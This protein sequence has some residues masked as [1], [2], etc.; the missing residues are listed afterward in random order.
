MIY[1]KVSILSPSVVDTGAWGEGS[2]IGEVALLDLIFEF[3]KLKYYLFA[4]SGENSS[5]I[6]KS[7]LNFVEYANN[8]LGVIF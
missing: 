1:G 5:F 2:N 3:R 6:N 4:R 7:L 8:L